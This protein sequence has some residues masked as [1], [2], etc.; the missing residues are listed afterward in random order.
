MPSTPPPFPVPLLPPLPVGFPV[1]PLPPRPV[2]LL[3]PAVPGWP[4]GPSM[5]DPEVQDAT[6]KM[7]AKLALRAQAR[8]TLGAEGSISD[9]LSRALETPPPTRTQTSAVIIPGHPVR[10]HPLRVA[11]NF[12]SVVRRQKI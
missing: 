4:P 9:F 7:A 11:S 12:R 8:T 5:I 10:D 3:V 1:G 6:R 2:T